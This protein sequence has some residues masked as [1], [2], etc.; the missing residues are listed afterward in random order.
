MGIKPRMPERT[1]HLVS[2]TE[3]ASTSCTSFY[4]RINELTS[5]NPYET[6]VK[7]K[8]KK[9][10]SSIKDDKEQEYFRSP[11]P[12]KK[13]RVIGLDC[14]PDIFT[15]AVIK[16]KSIS[17]AQTLAIHKDISWDGFK[18]WA[19]DTLDK[20]DLVVMESGSKSFEVVEVLLKLGFQSIVI[21]SYQVSR[22]Q[23]DFVDTDAI[24]SVRIA[25][26]FLTG[27]SKCVWVPDELTRQRQE[28]LHRYQKSLT[29]STAAVN[30]L[31]GLL[32]CNGVR[33]KKKSPKLNKTH[34]WILAQRD[35]S[36]EQIMLLKDCF[37]EVLHH[38]TRRKSFSSSFA[39]KSRK[40]HK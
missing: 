15:A 23:K 40:R 16:G 21:E 27:A 32:T 9:T 35:W 4:G 24:A 12:P 29:R 33:L 28:I 30:E 19:L 20:N 3:I 39:N 5:N 22:L 8:T 37:R 6:K 38:E 10:S 18:Q 13:G 14:H 31:R 1:F 2:H 7:T 34:E 25:H 11:A 36:E 17:E 26:T